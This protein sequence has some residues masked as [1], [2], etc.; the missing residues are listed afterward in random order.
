MVWVHQEFLEAYLKM[1]KKILVLGAGS[2]QK[3]F[4]F[5]AIKRGYKVL[6]FD[7]VQPNWLPDFEEIDFYNIDISDVDLC[8]QYSKQLEFVGVVSPYNDA[9]IL[10][11]AHIAVK[12]SLPG[13]GLVPAKLSRDKFQFRRFLQ[14]HG[15]NSPNCLA[16]KNETD[17]NDLGS[18]FLFP[19][20]IKPNDGSG[21]RGVFYI[22][23]LSDF[24]SRYLQTKGFSKNQVVLIE[25]FIK[26]DEF[27]AECLIQ[28][29][30]FILIGFCK[31]NRSSLPRLLDV[32]LIFPYYF[33]QKLHEKIIRELSRLVKLLKVQ[34]SFMHVEFIMSEENLYIVEYGVRGAAFDVYTKLISWSYGIDFNVVLLDLVLGKQIKLPEI[35]KF[36]VAALVFP[37]PITLGVLQEISHKTGMYKYENTQVEVQNLMEIGDKIALVENGSM[38]VSALFYYAFTNSDLNNAMN[39][40]DFN[41]R[42]E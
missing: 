17:I 36:K 28:D 34:T 10:S 41:M 25:S 6:L 42:V 13:P 29:G 30:N 37:E 16:I 20:V 31:K 33:E 40:F 32:S 35:D 27:S 5:T 18:N 23:S 7:K 12:N 26:G 11:A 24:N 8:T 1:N 14:S 38:R 22:E 19:A 15:L 3:S 39:S 4:V 2:F 21:S 9:G